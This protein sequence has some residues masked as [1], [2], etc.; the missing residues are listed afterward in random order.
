LS[1]KRI[2]DER[3]NKGARLKAHSAPAATSTDRE[4]PVFC[5]QYVSNLYCITGCNQEQ[6]A[7]FA[8]AIRNLSQLTWA[9]IKSS[10][11]H[12]LGTEKIERDSIKAPIPEHVTDDETFLAIRFWKK[13]PMVGYRE[14]EIFR[15][16]WFDANFSLYNH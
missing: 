14:R 5:L 1:P 12:G 6:K 10:H 11:R 9:E 13:A 2:K 15:I 7:A 4:K 3:R 16:I 8:D